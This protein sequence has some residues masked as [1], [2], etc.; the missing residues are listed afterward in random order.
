[1][2]QNIIEYEIGDFYK[3]W[4][5]NVDLEALFRSCALFVLY[6]AMQYVGIILWGIYTS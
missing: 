3:N 1:M 5:Q 6:R 2:T 4:I